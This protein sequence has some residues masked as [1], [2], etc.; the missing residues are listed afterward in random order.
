MCKG[1]WSRT[2][3]AVLELWSAWSALSCTASI[4]PVLYV[5]GWGH[6]VVSQLL[7]M[8][9]LVLC[10]SLGTP[11]PG[12]LWALLPTLGHGGVM[13]PSAEGTCINMK[14][15]KCFSFENCWKCERVWQLPLPFF[16]PWCC[17]LHLGLRMHSS[18]P[19]KPVSEESAGLGPSSAHHVFQS[20]SN[21]PN[22]RCCADP[23]GVR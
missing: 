9:W 12:H 13:A 21:I 23:L 3:R 5:L 6:C 15:L 10:P 2:M 16:I 4:R 17:N 20:G 19:T 22:T 8:Q 18:Y 7:L 14:H 11:V 1:T